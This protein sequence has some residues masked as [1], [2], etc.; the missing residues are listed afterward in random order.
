MSI[1]GQINPHQGGNILLSAVIL[2]SGATPRK[3]FHLLSHMR[4]VCISDRT[5]YY[6]QSQYLHPAVLS[7]WE[8]KQ[9]NLLAQRKS[10]GT[11][12]GDGRADSPDYS[13]EYGF[14]GII[15]L[16][17]NKFIHIELV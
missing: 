16:D 17:T 14:Y 12:D 7:V 5:F 2:F 8:T 6:H 9:H 10:Q 15:D 3:I 1:H 13:A 11:I 4:V